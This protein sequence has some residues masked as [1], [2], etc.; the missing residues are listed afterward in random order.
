MR[1]STHWVIWLWRAMGMRL[2]LMACSGDVYAVFHDRDKLELLVPSGSFLSPQ[3]ACLSEDQKTLFVP[4]YSAGVAA[5]RSSESLYRV[6]G[7]VL[8]PW[9]GRMGSI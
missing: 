1:R 8:W 6:D 9:T 3:T 2:F 4:D 5:S 7:Y